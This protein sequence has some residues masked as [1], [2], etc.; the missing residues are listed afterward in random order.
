MTS[1]VTA[2]LD[3]T[4]ERARL[5]R[6]SHLAFA[7][8]AAVCLACGA[9]AQDLV[10][11]KPTVQWW[12]TGVVLLLTLVGF[13]L[14]CHRVR[15]TVPAAGAGAFLAAYAAPVIG[16]AILAPEQHPVWPLMLVV[17]LFAVVR[18]WATFRKAAQLRALPEL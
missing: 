6:L 18:R 10:V 15:S 2:D 4:V 16:A 1:T 11:E 13:G 8:F 17:L 14:F 12:S 5:E 3:D 7:A 9:V